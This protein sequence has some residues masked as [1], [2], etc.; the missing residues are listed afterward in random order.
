MTHSE[1]EH[2]TYQAHGDYKSSYKHV[3]QPYVRKDAV[4]KVTGQARYAFDLELPGMLHAKT[5]HSPHARA[6]I[7]SIDTSRAKA[8][9]G[10]KAVI[11][12]EDSDITVGLY[13]QDKL[14]IATGETRYQGE[15]VA[16]VTATTEAIAEKAISLIEVE[17]EVLEPVRNLD[18][19]LEAKTLVHEDIAEIK[20][21]EGVFFPQP[22]SNIASL[23]KSRK[24]DLDKGMAEADLVV[25]NEFTLPAVAHVPLETHVSIVQA[26]PYSN[27]IRIWSSA[28]SPFAL[29]QLM[30][31]SFGVKESDIEVHIPFVGG[32]FGG[33]A[34][35]HLEPLVTLLSR[36]SG[37]APVK[38]RMTREQE[39]NYLPTR[40]GMR[41]RIKT[42][43]KKDGTMVASDIV[44]DWDSGAYADYGV[45]V[46]KTA[47][48]GGLGPYDVD[49]VSIVS[50][51]IYTN[52]V[53]STAYRGFGHLETLWTVERQ[54]DIL[55]QKLGIDP[56]EFRMKNILR[57]GSTTVTGER[58]TRSTGCPADCLSA[59]VK[60]IGW[61]GRKSE[62]ER[63]R[64]WK[65]GKV[66]GKGFAMI[67]KAPAMPPNT[68]T[69]VVMQMAG[70]GHVKIM[71][72]AIDYGQGALTSI[73]QIAAQ[74]L[75]LPMD[76]IEVIKETNTET[77]P[78]DWN[79]VASKYTF[80]GGN[81][82][83]QASR[84]ML[85]QM[86]DI[87]G[88]ALR[89]SPEVLTHGDGYIYNKHRP[90]RRIA[91]KDMALGYAY[92][93]GNGIGGPLI[94]HGICM[95]DGLTNLDPETGQGLPALA[96]TFGAHAVD[97]EV[98]VESGDITVLK[99]AS[100]FDLG[101]V[102]NERMVYGQVMGGVMQGI[103]SAILE[104]YKFSDDNVLLNPSFTDNK[105]PTF[106]DMP[107]EVVP[108]YIENPQLNG[109]Y[110]ARGVAE[111]TMISIPSAIGNA[112]YDALG[113]NFYHLPLT[114]ENV[115]L[116][117]A[118]GKKD[119]K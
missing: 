80:M 20:H 105:I 111:H 8:L 13:M 4:E 94:A 31:H 55:S 116:G 5:L 44:Y 102:I 91:Y 15:V 76:M 107:V 48:Y 14:A 74:E 118:S 73:A 41:G 12:G 60:E 112:L 77:N 113:I 65:T 7:V 68:A 19:A 90:E 82:T 51:T 22:D 104:G 1:L 101:Q 78:Y 34:G 57:P 70:D 100:A 85:D 63:A 23:N 62:E 110:G 6:R 49:N 79:T 114:P 26:D 64:E 40:A 46:G 99:V 83:I 67:Q 86:K 10:V 69:A 59:V 32:A 98:D 87:A 84:R 92:P 61:T 36:A 103:G 37:G 43:V 11:T 96:W 106:K 25:E 38:L 24:G 56:Y 16:A 89:C 21:V 9:V 33:K 108:I 115:A 72:G 109:P 97:I 75:D 71:I 42:G 45:N 29:R 2:C 88:Q 119:V 50:K 66:R 27:R 54:M 117:I 52:K 3:G 30:A 35:I 17:Y 53:F 81:A 93:D 58:V 18:D 28:Q 39:F 95:A 47:V